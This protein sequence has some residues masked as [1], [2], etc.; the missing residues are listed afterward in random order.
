MARGVCDRHGVGQRASVGV[1]AALDLVLQPLDTQPPLLR[2]RGAVSRRAAISPGPLLSLSHAHSGTLTRSLTN[3]HTYRAHH[4]DEIFAGRDGLQTQITDSQAY[5]W[6]DSGR[7]FLRR[8]RAR[9]ESWS[10]LT[11]RDRARASGDTHSAASLSSRRRARWL[12]LLRV[13]STRSRAD[14]SPMPLEM[15]C[16]VKPTVSQ[17]LKTVFSA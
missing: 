17:P 9:Q 1:R 12:R 11:P 4:D 6:L 7:P 3:T 14:S 5:G 15:Q 13:L 10:Q 8:E 2:S 16:A